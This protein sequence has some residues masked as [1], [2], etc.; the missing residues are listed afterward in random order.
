GIETNTTTPGGSGVVHIDD[1][2][3]YPTRC[4]AKYGPAG[5][6]T[7]DCFVDNE[8]FATL[9][10]YWYTPQLAVEYTFDTG[11]FD[12]S[13]NNRHGIDQNSPV[14]SGGVLTLDGTNFVDIPFGADNPFDGSSDFSIAMDFQTKVSSILI[15]SARDDVEENHSMSVYMRRW[16]EPFQSGVIYDNFFVTEA[17]AEDDPLDGEWHTMVVT[18]DADGGWD[19]ELEQPTGWAMVYL[20]GIPGDGTDMDPNIP[21]IAADTVR[22]GGSLNT[23][24]PYDQGDDTFVG[25]LSGSIDN[26]RIYNFALSQED[27]RNFPTVPSGPAD[28][29]MDGIIDFE[30]FA[31]LASTWLDE[32]LWP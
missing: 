1:V 29:N 5:D 20:D 30:D 19:D 7:D 2:R 15:S 17:V 3:L 31:I 8:D 18:Y 26:L 11:L 32:K 12:T 6:I 13:G 9:A 22:I 24:F 14:V 10:S 16:D 21:N 25:N 28:L 23:T 4:V 27:V